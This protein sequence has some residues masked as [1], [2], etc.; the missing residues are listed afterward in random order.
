MQSRRTENMYF[1]YPFSS[2]H[3]GTEGGPADSREH[4]WEVRLITPP[5]PTPSPP[6][7]FLGV[8]WGGRGWQKAAGTSGV[9]AYALEGR[10]P[11]GEGACCPL[12]LL[13]EP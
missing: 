8:E 9:A 2:T 11:V 10:A 5:F 6:S 1:G 4:V 7:S 13:G 12:A 3:S